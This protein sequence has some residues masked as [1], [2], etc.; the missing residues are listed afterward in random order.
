M[1]RT[2]RPEPKTTDNL[3][4][5][6]SDGA[7]NGVPLTYE[8]QWSHSTD[9]GSTWGGWGN[10][11]DTLDS[12]LTAKGE[13]WKAQA[14]AYDGVEYSGWVESD[15]VT[16]RNSPPTLEWVGEPPFGEGNTELV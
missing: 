1:L 16:I 8:Y 3:V 7:S 14:R 10:D 5:V 15:P 2:T 4:A 12:S 11:G 6:A 9:G 13:Q